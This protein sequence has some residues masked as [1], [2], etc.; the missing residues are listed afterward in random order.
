MSSSEPPGR[1]RATHDDEIG[2]HLRRTILPDPVKLA[3]FLEWGRPLPGGPA[4]LA[5]L[6]DKLGDRLGDD[7]TTMR[8]ALSNIQMVYVQM[9]SK[10]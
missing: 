6:V 3:L 1:A 10:A 9:K 5:A 7:I 8:D 4:A 2:N